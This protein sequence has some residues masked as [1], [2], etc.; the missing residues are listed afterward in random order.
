MSLKRVRLAL[1]LAL[2]VTGQGCG[3]CGSEIRST[4]PAPS[5]TYSAVVYRHD[6]GATT[7]FTVKVALTRGEKGRLSDI[8]VADSDHGAAPTEPDGAPR[9]DVAWVGDSVLRIEYDKR[10]R[11]FKQREQVGSV[12]IDYLAK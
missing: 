6:C 3:L 1:L 4:I 10:A 2:P 11:V 8:F 12:R 5:Q 9:A 7:D